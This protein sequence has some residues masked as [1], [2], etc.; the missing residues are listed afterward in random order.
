MLALACRI[1]HILGCVGLLYLVV[2]PPGLF[3]HQS[4]EIFSYSA[5][6]ARHH[7]IIDMPG[8]GRVMHFSGYGGQLGR[9]TSVLVTPHTT[10]LCSGLVYSSSSYL[11][12]I[13][14]KVYTAWNKKLSQP[15]FDH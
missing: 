14:S 12:F 8:W 13:Y 9:L 11:A 1:L 6:A 4:G 5:A 10:V 7:S 3:S 15:L 2:W